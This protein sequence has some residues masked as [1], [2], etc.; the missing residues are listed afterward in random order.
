MECPWSPSFMYLQKRLARERWMLDCQVL[1]GDLLIAL[2]FLIVCWQVGFWTTIGN[3]DNI[4][5]LFK[6]SEEL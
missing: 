6:T 1:K 4:G 5:W 2:S 3:R